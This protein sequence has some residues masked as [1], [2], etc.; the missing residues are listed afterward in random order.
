[1]RDGTFSRL[2]Y[3]SLI[4]HLAFIG[5]DTEVLLQSSWQWCT[6]PLKHITWQHYACYTENFQRT[7]SN[8]KKILWSWAQLVLPSEKLI[9]TGA[10][11][12]NTPHITM[13]HRPW[14]F[15]VPSFCPLYFKTDVYHYLPSPAVLLRSSDLYFLGLSP[16][17]ITYRSNTP[18]TAARCIVCVCVHV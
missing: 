15:P 16:S 6:D 14:L 5:N 13:Y 4:C 9:R 3:G 7:T 2:K 8:R 10:A 17:G 11:A 12:Y 1:M 18:A